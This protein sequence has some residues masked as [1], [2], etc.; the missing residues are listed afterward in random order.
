M[1]LPASPI[2]STS[3]MILRSELG[4]SLS[5]ALLEHDTCTCEIMDNTTMAALETLGIKIIVLKICAA[6]VANKLSAP[7]TLLHRGMSMF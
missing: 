3:A 1:N 2:N 5:R 7:L 4:M 6:V